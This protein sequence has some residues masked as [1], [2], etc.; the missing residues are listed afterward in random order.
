MRMS[1]IFSDE[2]VWEN[3]LG[4]KNNTRA[5][6]STDRVCSGDKMH[7]DEDKVYAVWGHG[8]TWD[9]IYLKESVIYNRMVL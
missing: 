4:N 9:W 2:E 1:R 6:L 5:I 8:D 3:I 7:T